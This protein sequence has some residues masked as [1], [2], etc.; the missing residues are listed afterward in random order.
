M[1]VPVK[2]VPAR[3][4]QTTWRLLS[5]NSTLFSHLLHFIPLQKHIPFRSV[6][7]RNALEIIKKRGSAVDIKNP[8]NIF[9]KEVLLDLQNLDA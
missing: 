7:L 9:I 8:L 1:L 3:I 4:S 2:L 5:I 6:S